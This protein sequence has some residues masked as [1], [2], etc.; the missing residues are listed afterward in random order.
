MEKM[1]IGEWELEYDKSKTLEAY[2]KHKTSTEECACQSCKNYYHASKYFSAEIRAFF[3]NMGVDVEKPIE[4]Y[5]YSTY[6]NGKVWYGGWYHIVGK[7]VKGKDIWVETHRA[8]GDIVYHRGDMH[9]VADDLE[10]GFTLQIY[11][12]NDNF[13]DNIFQ[14]EINFW[15]PWVLD[16]KECLKD[17]C[18]EE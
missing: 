6:K 10:V 12:H 5:D 11:L 3:E 14:M 1:V 15:V 4:V 18:T 16:D 17:F 9:K 13:P 2:K 7:I 8:D